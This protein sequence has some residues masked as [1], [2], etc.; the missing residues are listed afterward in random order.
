[1]TTQDRHHLQTY[2][3]LVQLEVSMV[4][5][6]LVLD[7]RGVGRSSMPRNRKAYTSTTMA[8]DVLC[9]MVRAIAP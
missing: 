5:Q 7:N 8:I 9:I 4:M 1:M 2:Q 3:T 6:L